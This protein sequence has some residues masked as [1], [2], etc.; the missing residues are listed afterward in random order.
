M[1]RFHLSTLV[2]CCV[3]VAT[4]S[5]C[6]KKDNVAADTTAAAATPSDSVHQPAGATPIKLADVA[7]KW[8]MRS[9]PTQGQKTPV[10]FILEAKNGTSGWTIT[11]PGRKPVAEHVTA[12]GDSLILE[13][14]PYPSVLR[15]GV[16][17]HTTG[18][19]R[20]QDGKIVG[21]NTAHYSVKTPDSVLVLNTTGVRAK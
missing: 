3:G 15:K 12:A 18:T 14:D 1:I 20:L 19:F 8:N 10:T 4:L 7:G 17:V 6:A 21:E 11:F 9:V 2:G 16:R 5:A 13:S